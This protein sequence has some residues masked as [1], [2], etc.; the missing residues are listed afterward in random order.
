MLR[1]L[2]RKYTKLIW[3][4]G[5]GEVFVSF[6]SI[7][8][9]IAVSMLGITY[10][11]G[12]SL[13][14]GFMGTLY[15]CYDAVN[16]FVYAKYANTKDTK[17]LSI[18]N[19]LGLVVQLITIIL[20]SMFMLGVLQ[21][22][23]LSQEANKTALLVIIG[24]SIG[25]LFFMMTI[26]YYVY[27][28]SEGKEKVATF[29]RL[30]VSVIN[31]SLDI[32]AIVNQWGIV[33][34]IAATVLSEVLEYVF[35]KIYS[36][37]HNIKFV[38]ATWREACNYIKFML[39]GYG[40]QLTIQLNTIGVAMAASRLGDEGYAIYGIIQTINNQLLWFVYANDMIVEI[41]YG[42]FKNKY[43]KIKQLFK[44]TLRVVIKPMY[45][46]SIFA[47][48]IAPFLL[49]ILTFDNGLKI[50]LYYLLFVTV[51]W[52]VVETYSSVING[53]VYLL[54]QYNTKIVAEILSAIIITIVTYFCSFTNNPYITYF[55]GWIWGY[56]VVFYFEYKSIMQNF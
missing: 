45:L 5:I 48:L 50:N 55:V 37:I 35:L 49:Y 31:I 10:L 25:T 15:L 19:K 23:G 53:W 52:I 26:P 36:I 40:V 39:Q 13:A 28:R 14:V 12:Y 3:A 24:R 9:M 44:D 17:I 1:E 11:A 6:T 34:V 46:Y 22:S 30:L 54:N 38:K 4:I 2:Q 32:L 16:T 7:I 43:S 33:G 42:E 56:I 18:S 21:L 27:Y 51:F 29:S 47:L 20:V 8:D 41:L